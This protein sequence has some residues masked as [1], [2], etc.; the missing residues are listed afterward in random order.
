MLRRVHDRCVRAHE[1]PQRDPEVV[2]IEK[3]A[4]SEGEWRRT[5]SPKQ[6]HILRE[7]G[8]EPPFTGTYDHFYERGVYRCAACDNELFDSGAKFNSRTG[9]PSFY[10]PAGEDSV[11]ERA[12][13]SLGMTRTEIKCARCGSHLGHVFDDGPPPTGLRYCMNSLALKFVPAKEGAKEAS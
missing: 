2:M 3:I 9:W 8:T 13:R 12:D 1:E 5:L 6:Y 7:S 11:G 4:K 10:E